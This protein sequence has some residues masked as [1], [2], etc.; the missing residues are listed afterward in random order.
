MVGIPASGKAQPNWTEIPTPDG[1]KKLGDLKDGDYVFDRSGKST[2]VIGVYPQGKLDNYEVTLNDGRKTWC[3]DEHIWATYT[4]RGNLKN[5]T[6]R[7]MLDSGLYRNS[8][9]VKSKR[10]KYKIPNNEAVEYKERD[11]KVEPYV[12]GALIGDGSLKSRALNI[13]SN[14][15]FIV[16]KISRMIGVPDYRRLHEKNYNWG[17]YLSEPR[18][19]KYGGK[20]VEKAQTKELIGGLPEIYNKMSHEKRIPPEYKYGSVKQRIELLQGLLDTD[21]SININKGRYDIYYDTTSE[22][23]VEDIKEVLYSL[24]I[25]SGVYEDKR[26]KYTKSSYTIYLGVDNK[27]KG[28]L[29]TLPRKKQVA[30]EAKEVYKRR[31]YSRSGIVKV[32]RVGVEEMTCIMVENKEN[33][34]LTNDFI[35]THNTTYSKNRVEDI[36]GKAIR[37][38]SDDIRKV[39]NEPDHAEVFRIMRKGLREAVESNYYDEIYYDATNINRKRRR[40]LYRNIKNWNKEVHV[41][42]IFMSIPYATALVRNSTRSEISKVPDD[43]I[44]RMHRQLQIPRIGV[45]CD[46]FEVVGLPI[47]EEV[48]EVVDN[49][50]R[51]ENIFNNMNHSNESRHWVAELWLSNTEHNSKWHVEDIFTHI[52]MCIENSYNKD[53]KQIALFHDLGKGICKETRE[54]GYSSYF[55][56]ADVGAHYYLNYIGLTKYFGRTIPDHELD[57]IEATRQHMLFHDEIG[58]KNK[59]NNRLNERV[60][61]L[62]MEFAEIDSMS[63]ISEEDMIKNGKDEG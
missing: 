60:M 10:A 47:F 20:Q 34:Y 18:K 62:G 1:P 36:N 52:N 31:D 51:V 24:G 25:L 23:L 42:I 8:K 39:Y 27:Y 50:T 2:K 58:R 57:K 38:S 33:L 44:L 30:E 5:R 4:S 48:S 22:G 40:S 21:G 16:K 9:G 28:D 45:D 49:P 12:V 7:E 19:S 32:E 37:F 41:N 43:V 53:L 35:V 59:D 63:K 54:D 56:H 26:D 17:F 15:E 14:D 46:R 29:F 3:N 61:S 55:S 11:F 13:S 6:L